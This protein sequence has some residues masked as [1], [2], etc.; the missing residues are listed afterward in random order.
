MT[1]LTEHDLFSQ[2]LEERLRELYD[3]RPHILAVDDE[4]AILN[5][6]ERILSDDYE[7]HLAESGLQGLEILTTHPEIEVIVSD[8]RMPHMS[9]TEFLSRSMNIN[10]DCIRIILTGYVDAKDLV[11]SINTGKVFQY[12]T[13][14]LYTSPSPR[15]S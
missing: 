6:L 7:V 12:I 9:G 8:Q 4:P 5:M 2:K 13:C 14:L 11:A 1:K 15:D 10:P 3:T